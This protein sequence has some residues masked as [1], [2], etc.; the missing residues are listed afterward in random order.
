[1]SF[2]L[3]V[4][5]YTNVLAAR[6]CVDAYVGANRLEVGVGEALMPPFLLKTARPFVFAKIPGPILGLGVLAILA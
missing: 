6:L 1:M 4:A 2:R 3:C 5:L